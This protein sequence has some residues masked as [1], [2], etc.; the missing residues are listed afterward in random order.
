MT[1]E[2]AIKKCEKYNQTQ[3]LRFYDELTDAERNELLTQIED[4]DFSLIER[5]AHEAKKGEITPIKAMTAE[6]IKENE[7][8]FKALGLEEIRKGHVAAVLLAGGM[9]TRLG[10]DKPKGCFNIGINRELYIFECLINNT[11]EV[12]KE[13]G[14]YPYF[15]V[16]T[17]DK[18]HDMT[19]EFFTE[20]NFFGYDIFNI[21][22]NSTFQRSCTITCIPTFVRNII[23]GGIVQGKV[24]FHVF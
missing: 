13:A 4:T 7:E 9:G 14:N 18:N 12:V 10:S 20:H 21:L 8:K 22:L 24:N 2:E 1:K 15:F 23:F 6:R 19:V 17:S 16:M 11:M 3:V 5:A